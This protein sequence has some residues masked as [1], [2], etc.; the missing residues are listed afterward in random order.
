MTP[1]AA[2]LLLGGG[3][4]LYKKKAHKRLQVPGRAPGV[5]WE[6]EAY[7]PP[8][9]PD[10]KP[11]LT[12]TKDGKKVTYIHVYGAGSVAGPNGE[13]PLIVSYYSAEGGV[14]YSLGSPQEAQDKHLQT[15]VMAIRDLELKKKPT[16]NPVPKHPHHALKHNVVKRRR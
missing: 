3:Y 2:A 16:S 14:K 5:I 6:L 13:T 15:I 8:P 11:I 7:T 9:R 1:I 10:G 4:Y 12:T